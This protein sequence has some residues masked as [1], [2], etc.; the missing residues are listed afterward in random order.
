MD[1]VTFTANIYPVGSGRNF[2][3]QC[4]SIRKNKKFYIAGK[5]EESLQKYNDEEGADSPLP[6]GSDRVLEKTQSPEDDDDMEHLSHWQIDLTKIPQ[7]SYGL[8]CGTDPKADL[9]LLRDVK[10]VSFHHFSF[11]FDDE[12]R[13]IV[14]DL[15]LRIIAGDNFLKDINPIIVKAGR[16][17]E[18]QVIVDPFDIT[19]KK[20]REHVDIFRAGTN[21]L[22]RTFRDLDVRLPTRLPSDLQ[23]P[24]N[25]DVSLTKALFE[26]EGG[27]GRVYRAWNAM[28][29]SLSVLKE[30]KKANKRYLE[31]RHIVEFL[32]YEAGPPPQLQFEYLAGGSV[33]DH[34]EEGNNFS[35]FECVQITRQTLSALAYLYGLQPPIT[36]TDISSGNVPVKHRRPDSIFVKLGDFGFSK[37]GSNL[38]TEIGTPAFIPPEFLDNS[39]RR[40]RVGFRNTAATLSKAH[41][42]STK[43]YAITLKII[44]R[45][46][47]ILW[48]AYS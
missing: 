8:V 30:P 31:Q 45:P 41:W 33:L 10:G 16:E 29:G 25:D 11:T 32:G 12:Y 2:I 20:L 9:S 36:H 21:N 13:F 44:S 39:L 24:L 27:Y 3:T 14:R 46:L 47:T 17:I 18:L 43:P 37:E 6:T 28:T 4:R 5:R 1:T 7:T 40:S 19:C 15:G 26:A 23:K 22:E 48:L 42:T 34:L 38:N 35:S